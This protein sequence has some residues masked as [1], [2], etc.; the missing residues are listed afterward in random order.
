M[1]ETARMA[2]CWRGSITLPACTPCPVLLPCYGQCLSDLHTFSMLTNI[3]HRM[4]IDAFDLFYRLLQRR[5]CFGLFQ[6]K[7]VCLRILQTKR[8]FVHFW[9]H[10][11]YIFSHDRKELTLIKGTLLVVCHVT[12]ETNWCWGGSRNGT[13][14]PRLHWLPP[15]NSW[16]RSVGGKASSSVSFSVWLFIQFTFAKTEND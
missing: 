15:T 2:S 10:I 3:G 6:G 5:R 9:L 16:R 11:W 13:C 8:K 12:M 14:P 7:E 4:V 1:W